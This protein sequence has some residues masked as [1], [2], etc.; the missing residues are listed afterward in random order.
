MAFL[1]SS[2]FILCPFL[3][4]APD[5]PKIYQG[6]RVKTTVKEL[7]QKRRALQAAESRVST[8]F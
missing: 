5:K 8:F 2:D 3:S 1:K 6:V 7:L 4:S